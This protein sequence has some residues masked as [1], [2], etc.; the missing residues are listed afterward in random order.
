MLD[1]PET[2]QARR[3]REEI[4][5]RRVPLGDVARWFA[6]WILAGILV[7]V[8]V[9]GLW[10]A[11]SAV[12]DATYAIG[13]AA[14]ALAFLALLWELVRALGPEGG[15]GAFAIWSIEDE[16]SLGILIAVLAILAVGGLV[17]AATVDS[18]AANGA[19]YGLFAFGLV[20]IFAN[21]KH[22]FDRRE[23]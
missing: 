12:D 8:I 11:S 3:R 10:C 14:A 19:G 2:D 21:L 20:F 5:A 4:E 6:P 9:A 17:L 7:V 23:R 16:T 22:Y 15:G 1:Q 13:I 18:A